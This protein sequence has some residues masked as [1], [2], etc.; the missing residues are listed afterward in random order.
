MQQELDRIIDKI[1]SE[2][3][4]NKNDKMRYA[5]LELG[6]I[7]H[8]D[9]F[10]F[11]TIYNQLLN[12]KEELQ[13]DIDTIDMMINNT[14]N[15]DYNVICKNSADMLKYIFDNVGIECEIKRTTRQDI[16]KDKDKV[17]KINH[18]F[19]LATGE[20]NK[21]YFITLTP[22]LPN[23]QI[24][25]QTSHFGNHIPYVQTEIR[26]SE[27]GER[28][29]DLFQA[30]EGEKVDDSTF[31]DEELKEIDLKIGRQLINYDGKLVYAD[32]LFDKIEE[33]YKYNNKTLSDGEYLYLVR[34]E[35]PFYYDLCN[36][37]NGE[38]SLDEILESD[39]IPSEEEIKDSFI[40]SSRMNLNEDTLNDLKLFILLQVIIN[41][42]SKFNVELDEYILD[43]FRDKLE[44]KKYDE[45]LQAFNKNFNGKVV[46]QLGPFNPMMQFKK[47][48]TMFKKVDEI[49][50]KGNTSE[51]EKER[52][53]KSLL[54]SLKSVELIFVPEEYLPSP[55][56]RLNSSYLTNKIVKSFEKIF[57]IGH[58][59]E[60]NNLSFGEQIPI[61]KEILQRIFTDSKLKS[62]DE[63]VVGY[64]EDRSP[65]QNRIF[66]TVLFSKETNDPYYLMIVRNSLKERENK[67]GLVPIVFDLKR[68]TLSTDMSMT[69]IYSSFFIIKDND[70]KIMI[71]QIEAQNR[72]K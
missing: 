15:F 39:K 13:Y 2:T 21:K 72:N 53:I 58:V 44:A 37:L 42:Y 12:G 47:T 1:N 31:T 66:A 41:I 35:T 8:K 30:Y 18:Y 59:G 5:Y 60:F 20:N 69:D 70:F 14:D 32:E 54:D 36:L 22:D 28:V 40:D 23:I 49:I 4:W 6:K 65:L 56:P 61:I 26:I 16:F 7:V 29:K 38:K 33:Y 17:I 63:T 45:M 67:E 11:Y 43:D 25:K 55:G 52:N 19:I 64:R 48:V 9:V 57:D 3:S 50:S 46:T 34:C 27:T 71:E 24:G 10:F 62:Q 51:E 68:N